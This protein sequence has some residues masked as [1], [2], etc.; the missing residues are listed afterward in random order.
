MNK[1]TI[2]NK[3]QSLGVEMFSNTP[4]N[5]TWF[6]TGHSIRIDF[7][8]IDRVIPCK[9]NQA[10]TDLIPMGVELLYRKDDKIH[11]NA[12]YHHF[13]DVSTVSLNE[14]M[15]LKDSFDLKDLIYKTQSVGIR[16]NK[17]A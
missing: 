8:N 6:D 10:E 15:S 3:L 4:T 7:W 12:Y 17:G 14:F 13:N 9:Y 1:R 5:I 11:C 16:L 2:V